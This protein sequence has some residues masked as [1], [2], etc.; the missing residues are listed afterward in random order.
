MLTP[1][2]PQRLS[3][4]ETF[5]NVKI[6]GISAVEAQFWTLSSHS[7]HEKENVAPVEGINVTQNLEGSFWASLDDVPL[8]Q[9]PRRSLSGAQGKG[10]GRGVDAQHVAA[11]GL[12]GLSQL[13]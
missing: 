1:S 11:R 5:S 6:A 9:W 12:L 13:R 4:S 8:M 7:I 2:V 10:M 3:N